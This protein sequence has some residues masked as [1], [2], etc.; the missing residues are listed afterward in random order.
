MHRIIDKNFLFLK[1][2]MKTTHTILVFILLIHN[3]HITINLN[4]PLRV[5]ICLHKII[6]M[7][8]L[9]LNKK[10]KST[11]TI[12]KIIPNIARTQNTTDNPIFTVTNTSFATPSSGKPSTMHKRH[13][14][15]SSMVFQG[16]MHIIRYIVKNMSLRR[17]HGMTYILDESIIDLTSK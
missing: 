6:D 11:H 16:S 5:N 9:F 15:N 13:T 12:V 7:N 1:M 8:L 14:I 10:L 3:S 2:R 4:Y 17:W